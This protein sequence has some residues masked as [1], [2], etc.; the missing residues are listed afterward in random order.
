MLQYGTLSAYWYSFCIFHTTQYHAFCWIHCNRHSCHTG[1]IQLCVSWCPTNNCIFSMTAILHV[2]MTHPCSNNMPH[3]HNVCLANSFADTKHAC[4]IVK[5]YDSPTERT[6]CKIFADAKHACLIIKNYELNIHSANI[7]CNAK[8]D[9][10]SS[11]RGPLADNTYILMVWYCSRERE[12]CTVLYIIHM[13]WV[14]CHPWAHQ[15]CPVVFK[16]QDLLP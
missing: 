8:C 15:C 4:L 5:N 1:G 12:C 9:T 16:T 10:P 13:A 7:L 11:D 14:Q 6:S 2:T 3:P